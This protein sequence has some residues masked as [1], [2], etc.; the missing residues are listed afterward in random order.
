MHISYGLPYQLEIL[1]KFG[2]WAY[3]E[4][5]STIDAFLALTDWVCVFGC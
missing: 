5:I 3:R 1:N 2:F 4:A